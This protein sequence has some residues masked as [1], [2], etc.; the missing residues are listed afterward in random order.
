MKNY[1]HD[2]RWRSSADLFD[3][4]DNLKSCIRNLKSKTCLMSTKRK[5]IGIVKGKKVYYN[6]LEEYSTTYGNLQ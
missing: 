5:Y 2:V 1:R 4:Y 3:S 6:V